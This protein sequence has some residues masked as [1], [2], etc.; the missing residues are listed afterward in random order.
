[1]N[2][3]LHA[4]KLSVFK[5]AWGEGGGGEQKTKNNKTKKKAK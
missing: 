2:A 5:R 4:W 3:K 1:M